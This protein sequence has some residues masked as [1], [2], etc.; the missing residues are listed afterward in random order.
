MNKKDKH[1]SVRRKAAVQNGEPRRL[2]TYFLIAT[3]ALLL[4]SGFFFAGRQHFSSMDY[5]MKNSKLRR[6][7]DQLEAEKR[8]L[9][10]AREISLSPMEL[11]KAAKKTGI[12][13][14]SA[15]GIVAQVASSTK[16]KAA[17]PAASAEPRSLIIKTAAVTPAKPVVEKADLKPERAE[18]VVKRTTTAAE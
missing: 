10:L 16:D 11:K 4:V 12:I 18:R 13:D 14:H 7:I 9:L 1:V 2:R 15:D 3:C 8:R 17:P 6:Q 5:G